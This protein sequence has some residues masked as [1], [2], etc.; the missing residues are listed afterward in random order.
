M[1]RSRSIQLV[2]MGTVPLLLSACDGPAAQAPPQSTLAYQDLKQCIGDGK[3]ST[4]I[5]EKA[6]ADAVQEQ[7]R[8]GPRFGTLGECQSQFGYD[9]CHP[10]QTASGSW[11]M[12]ALAG[13]MVGRAF[14]SN[15]YYDNDRRYGPGY[16]GGYGAPLYRARGDRAEWRT[17]DGTRFGAGARGPGAA[18]VG[19]TLSRGGFGRSSAARGSWG[20]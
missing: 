17:A 12:P 10:V 19:E 4:E 15:H 9:Q 7:Y 11:F 1:K 3:V 13:F 8:A 18:S 14:G 5:C 2:L 20:G 16:G 6:Y